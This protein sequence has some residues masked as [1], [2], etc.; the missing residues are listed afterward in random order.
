MAVHTILLDPRDEKRIFIGISAAG[1][2]R[3]DDGG[4][5]WSSIAEGL[6]SDFGFFVLASPR[7]PGTAWV[8][9]PIASTSSM[10]AQA[11]SAIS[12]VSDS[13]M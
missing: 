11:A 4:L 8:M 13:I 1:A 7:T 2:F 12:R 9:P 5:Q 10:I 3:T 6:P